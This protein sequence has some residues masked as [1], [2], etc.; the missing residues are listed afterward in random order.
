MNYNTLIINI[1]LTVSIFSTTDDSTL[2]ASPVQ[3]LKDREIPAHKE[4]APLSLYTVMNHNGVMQEEWSALFEGERRSIIDQA[5]HVNEYVKLFNDYFKECSPEQLEKHSEFKK[6]LAKGKLTIGDNL[7]Q[8]D[9]L[10]SIESVKGIIESLKWLWQARDK[11]SPYINGLYSRDASFINKV[12]RNCTILL[13]SFKTPLTPIQF[14]HVDKAHKNGI[15]GKRGQVLVI[16]SDLVSGHSFFKNNS[17]I[18]GLC[19][20]HFNDDYRK[21]SHGAHVTGIVHQIAP[22]AEIFVEENDKNIPVFTQIKIIVTSYTTPTPLFHLISEK[23]QQAI[24]E[25]L[26]ENKD[27]TYTYLMIKRIF[28]DTEKF[29]NAMRCI[30]KASD[31]LHLNSQ[32][33]SEKENEINEDEPKRYAEDF[34]GTVIKKA[35]QGSHNDE[36]ELIQKD[37][38]LFEGKL[39]IASFGNYY[40]KKKWR[41]RT[42]P[43]LLMNDEFLNQTILAINIDRENKLALSSNRPDHTLKEFFQT[44]LK[45]IDSY[46]Q[47]LVDQKLQRVQASSLCALGMNVWSAGSHDGYQFASGTSMSAPT[48][49]GVAALIEG[50]YSDFSANEIRE[51]L[52]NSASREFVIGTDEHELHVIDLPK[53]QVDLLNEKDFG[54]RQYIAFDPSQYGSGILN[55]DAALKYAEFKSAH[56][57]ASVEELVTMLIEWRRN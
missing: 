5:K 10:N 6:G 23:K 17:N 57:S 15:K 20:H 43:S 41:Y 32:S 36:Q 4:T 25:I 29:E 14:S 2:Y 16:E 24:K 33:L 46:D 49:A 48:I 55:A 40:K 11:L 9:S 31:T 21:S 30:Y 50:I 35:I 45:N 39:R 34:A 37:I 1:L 42:L 38:N 52:L 18:K 19:E 13:E 26:T 51:C 3:D 56:H 22:K 27:E 53:E 7:L 8:I 28:K 47:K 54:L 12:S 44:V